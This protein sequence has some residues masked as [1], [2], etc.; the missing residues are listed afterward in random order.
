MPPVR[1]RALPQPVASFGWSVI[2]GTI[3][4]SSA[5][6]A[7]SG[8]N[9]T[10]GLI[11]INGS[12]VGGSYATGAVTGTT[13]DTGG[14]IGVLQSGVVSASYATGAVAGAQNTG[15]LIRANKAT[16]QTSYATGAVK[17]T[18]S[19]TGG[20]IGQ[21]AGTLQASYATGA[22]TGTA[23]AGGLVALNTAAGN[24]SSSYATGA[25]TGTDVNVGGLVGNNVGAVSASYS[26]GT[27]NG[28]GVGGF[29]GANSGTV[30]SSYW[31]MQTSG[32]TTSAG[33]SGVVG[34]TT[35]QLQGVL[36]AGFNATAWSTGTGLYPYLNWQF[37]AGTTPQS[38]SGIAHQANGTSL[39][40]AVLAGSVNGAV[41]AGAT[42]ANGYYYLLFA[43]GTA[44]QGS[45]I[46]IDI[47]GNAVKSNDYVQGAFGSLRNLD[48]NAGT[49]NVRTDATALSSVASS[50][51][52]VVGSTPTTDLLFTTPG[53]VL[54]PKAGTS[55]SIAASGAFDVDQALV[56]PNALLLTAA[57]GL[58]IGSTGAL[59][60]SSGNATLVG[61][62]FVN[63]AGAAAVSA[64]DGRWLIYSGDPANDN[65]GGLAYDFKQYGATYGETAVAQA[66]GNGVLYSVAPTVGLSGTVSKTYD[67][68]TTVAPGSSASV[69]PATIRMSS[70][71][72]IRTWSTA[73]RMPAPARRSPP[74]AWRSPQL[75]MAAPSF[76]AMP[77]RQRRPAIS[78]RS[79]RVRSR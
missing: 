11:G 18:G 39:A 41:F 63:N 51:A 75:L 25:V 57:G 56:V 76:T 6:G 35:A 9:Y 15:G 32:W 7:V 29:I 2:A 68:N 3:V 17:G 34:L 74:M 24:V 72:V 13:L 67:G 22:V 60:S 65:R 4:N 49:L 58:T 38:L 73:T 8:V 46:F 28:T 71:S 5:T 12:N 30:I 37:A 27:V 19:R 23:A 31:D 62:S 66:T 54:T 26:T 79:R 53:G 36:Q 45:G 55:V 70:R 61:S 10:G 42:G 77:R 21:N 33:G 50:L 20:L 69:S 47:A 64:P 44:A 1:S 43:Q 14:L 59:S 40:G 52:S 16:V 48:L 78:A